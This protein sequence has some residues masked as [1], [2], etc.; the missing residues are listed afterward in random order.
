MQIKLDMKI[1]IFILIFF[2]TNQINVYLLL[3]IFAFFHELTHLIIGLCVG[4]RPSLFE[5]KPIGFSVSFYNKAS[6]YNVKIKNGNLIELKKIVVYC[7]GPLFNLITA[8]FLY[9]VNSKIEY[10]YINLIIFIFNII[11]IY[12]LDGG[13]ILKSLIYIWCRTKA[14]LYCN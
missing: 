13:R 5:I 8:I 3:M 1:L 12:P 14:I 4:F 10:V 7:A 11:P 2:F 6:D 9:I